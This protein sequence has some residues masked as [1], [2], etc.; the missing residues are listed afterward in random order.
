MH[1]RPENWEKL[2][3]PAYRHA[4]AASQFKRFVPF[5]ITAL[6]KQRQ[7]SQQQLAENAGLTQGVISRAEDPDNGNLAVNTILRIA[8]G[9]DRVFVGQFM[10]YGDFE[11][12]RKGLAED[13]VVLDFEQENA[14]FERDAESAPFEGTTAKYLEVAAVNNLGAGKFNVVYID[15]EEFVP[16]PNNQMLQLSLPIP[17]DLRIV[18][19]PFANKMQ[20]AP[21]REA[22]LTAVGGIH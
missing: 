16:V 18:G 15:T 4:L 12:W 5:Q 9:L 10:S 11:E 19:K 20:N 17:A 2:Q 6:R 13:M 21:A 22:K 3:N 14:K 7:W 8:N 1:I